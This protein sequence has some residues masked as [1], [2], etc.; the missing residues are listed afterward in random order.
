MFIAEKTVLAYVDELQMEIVKTILWEFKNC[1][2]FSIYTYLIS[3]MYYI[4]CDSYVY[5]LKI[6]Q[7]YYKSCKCNSWWKKTQNTPKNQTLN[8]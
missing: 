3:E 8:I 2:V 4:L 1:N 5:L 6:Y 7:P